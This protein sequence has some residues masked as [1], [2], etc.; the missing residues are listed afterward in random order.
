MSQLAT[1][2]SVS[3]NIVAKSNISNVTKQLG[4]LKDK[5]DKLNKTM[6]TFTRLSAVFDRTLADNISSVTKSLGQLSGALKA[7]QAV[8][9]DDGIKKVT[10]DLRSLFKMLEKY[11][12]KELRIKIHVETNITDELNTRIRTF[13]GLYNRMLRFE[14]QQA[15][16]RN[17]SQKIPQASTQPTTTQPSAPTS[18]GG[19][20]EQYRGLINEMV[21]FTATFARKVILMPFNMMRG[22]INF[23][24]YFDKYVRQVAQGLYYISGMFRLLGYTM[25]M[26]G[27][28]LGYQLIRMLRS[29]SDAT[30][31]EYIGALASTMFITKEVTNSTKLMADTFATVRDVAQ[32]TGVALEDVAEA[33]YFIGSAGY[34]NFDVAQGIL[35]NIS[36]VAFATGSKPADILKALITLMNSYDIEMSKSIDVLN[37]VVTAVAYGVFEMSDLA[38]VLQKISSFAEL[39]NAPLD[40]ILGT[41]VGL[42]QTGLPPE[43]LRTSYSQF[44]MD[45]VKKADKFEA[46][47]IRTKYWTGTTWEQMSPYMIMQQ[48][49]RM[50]NTPLARQQF[51][52]S[53]GLQ[54]RS[55][56]IFEKMLNN[57]DK[58]SEGIQAVREG[59]ESNVLKQFYDNMQ[60]TV[61][62]HFNIMKNAVDSFKNT[63][64]EIYKSDIIATL[65]KVTQFFQK[66][67]KWLESD[68]NKQLLANIFKQLV[69]ISLLLITLGTIFI[70]ISLLVRTISGVIE[71]MRPSIMLMAGVIVGALTKFSKE[72]NINAES[73]SNLKQLTVNDLLNL[74]TEVIAQVL[75]AYMGATFGVGKK[76]GENLGQILS[77]NTDMLLEKEIPVGLKFSLV[78]VNFLE[79]VYKSI[80]EITDD[81]LHYFE[82]RIDK[83]SPQNKEAI[84]RLVK[85]LNNLIETALK[86]AVKGINIVIDVLAIGIQKITFGDIENKFTEAVAKLMAALAVAFGALRIT[87]GPVGWIM[88]MSLIIAFELQTIFSSIK[89]AQKYLK[90][91]SQPLLDPVIDNLK[92]KYGELPSAILETANI[93]FAD[94][95]LA[96]LLKQIGY[97]RTMTMAE[98]FDNIEALVEQWEQSGMPAK[99][100]NDM[101]IKTGDALQ[102]LNIAF[103][104]MV[105][106]GISFASALEAASEIVKGIREKIGSGSMPGGGSAFAVGGYTGSGSTYEPAGIV[107]KGEYVVPA[108][109][110][111]KHP[112]LI[113][114]L[115]SRRMKGY[116][117]GGVV[118]KQPQWISQFLKDY[119]KNGISKALS[120]VFNNTIDYVTS[121]LTKNLSN[122]GLGGVAKKLVDGLGSVVKTVG[123]FAIVQPLAYQWQQAMRSIQFT[124]KSDKGWSVN[125][126]LE[127]IGIKP[128]AYMFGAMMDEKNIG[129]ENNIINAALQQIFVNAGEIMTEMLMKAI[130]AELQAWLGS[131]DYTTLQYYYEATQGRALPFLRTL[132]EGARR[133]LYGNWKDLYYTGVADANNKLYGFASGGYTGSGTTY[134]PAGIVH[135]GEYVVPQWVVRKYPHLVG[136]L[137]LARRRG[138]ASGTPQ[139]GSKVLSQLGSSIADVQIGELFNDVMGLLE[140][141]TDGVLNL[142]NDMQ[143]LI[144]DLKKIFTEVMNNTGIIAD[145][146]EQ[147]SG[148]GATPQQEQPW[149]WNAIFSKIF[150]GQTSPVISGLMQTVKNWQK[151][152]QGGKG[153]K[154]GAMYSV[155]SGYMVTNLPIFT[156]LPQMLQQLSQV[157]NTDDLI[158]VFKTMKEAAGT[159][160]KQFTDGLQ[161]FLESAGISFE[162]AELVNNIV[163][164]GTQAFDALEQMLNDFNKSLVNNPILGNLLATYMPML[165]GLSAALGSAVDPLLGL[166]ASLGSL[167]QLLNAGTTI[168]QAIFAVLQPVLNDLLAPLI[169]ILV[170]IGQ[171]IGTLLLP[172]LQMLQPVILA[173]A[174]VFVWLANTIIIPI[175]KL[176]YTIFAAIRNAFFILYNTVSDIVAGLTFGLVRLAKVEVPAL[177]EEIN[178][179]FKPIDTGGLTYLG[180]VAITGSSGGS[181]GSGTGVTS[182]AQNISYTINWTTEFNGAVI[183]D[184]EELKTMLKELAEELNLELGL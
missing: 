182:Q 116:A 59:Q 17:V 158:N 82:G 106:N 121:S 178:N 127:K 109:M 113:A 151:M 72:F 145:T 163:G 85:S 154:E 140:K 86:I 66:M 152:A 11:A 184:K 128:L 129:K 81:V 51:V 58:V 73:L 32:E 21:N 4:N 45:L 155:I 33:L 165:D 44:L 153:T 26:V 94:K 107:H 46:A 142:A 48:V 146:V 27:S 55:L 110:V 183:A 30:K 108:W 24:R 166:I 60:N 139:E 25:T 92:Q 111:R 29:L 7:L 150:K 119:G 126:D 176:I 141:L 53:L 18:R 132:L 117:E 70:G 10:R 63:I 137:E 99:I 148:L 123:S 80:D 95:H 67:S 125:I 49:A 41:L 144:G 88:T 135:K 36:T 34:K 9:K 101:L 136:Q 160:L 5:M 179:L 87:R 164:V 114:M 12:G 122:E 169:G 104:L 149:D 161:A 78:G 76:L 16:R 2:Y 133:Y 15:S 91:V 8:S 23:W 38:S 42:S 96:W 90:D 64:L 134:E 159:S 173:V 120:N 157:K 52:Q 19:M 105:E 71:L 43:M 69:K 35:K 112:E 124:Y 84:D 168:A 50:Y 83:I 115:E 54:K 62:Y 174:S 89:D 74:D 102:T 130:N 170:I 100:L 103:S 22:Y 177:A 6:Q 167:E 31:T 143:K 37:S 3:I 47:G 13:A 118:G 79:A 75:N 181:S 57:L 156:Q 131:D 61:T 93:E 40:E 20:L 77:G 97:D 39:A 14:K 98:V 172:I 147:G 162:G 28:L 175:A 180:E 68:E 65:D 56:A 171:T 138:F 1:S